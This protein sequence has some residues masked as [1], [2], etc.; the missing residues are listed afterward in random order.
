MVKDIDSV[1]HVGIIVDDIQEAIHVYE[2]L[3]FQITPISMHS[4]TETKEGPIVPYGSGNVTAVFPGNYFEIVA[5]I[6][7]T[8]DTQHLGF[9]IDAALESYE[10]AHIICFGTDDVDAVD[11]RLQ[12][13]GIKTTG[14]VNLQ[15]DVDTLEGVRSARFSA[16]GI[17]SESTPEGQIQAAFHH[18]PEFIHQERYLSHPNKVIG[19]SDVVLCSDNPEELTQRYVKFTGYASKKHNNVNVIKLPLSRLTIVGRDNIENILPG[20]TVP[21]VPSIVGVGYKST[22]LNKVR[23]ILEKNEVQYTQ[24]N[25]KIHVPSNVACGCVVTFEA[26]KA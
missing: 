21:A 8:N 18:T 6:D 19:L 12:N 4:G 2:K 7:K 15:R 14:V 13:E 16:T 20:V 22:D 5:N 9:D 24:K 1:N 23:E 26:E 10:G 3:G 17:D 11:K 25:N